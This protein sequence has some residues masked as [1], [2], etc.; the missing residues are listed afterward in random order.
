[1]GDLSALIFVALAVAWA[2]Q[3]LLVS[4]LQRSGSPARAEEIARD[5]AAHAIPIDL[6]RDDDPSLPDDSMAWHGGA[7]V[8]VRTVEDVRRLLYAWAEGAPIDPDALPAA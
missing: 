2:A 6:W 3:S 1:M 7:F 5:L 8:G 4:I